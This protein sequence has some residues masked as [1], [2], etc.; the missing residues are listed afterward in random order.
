MALILHLYAQQT[1]HTASICLH[2]ENGCLCLTQKQYLEVHSDIASLINYTVTIFTS[3]AF[4]VNP[5]ILFSNSQFI[6]THT[7]LYIASSLIS[8][9]TAC[10]QT[11]IS[12]SPAYTLDLPVK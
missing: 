9:W 2:T 7:C 4:L 11:R 1:I 6:A 12:I 3:H 10:N 5:R 8:Y